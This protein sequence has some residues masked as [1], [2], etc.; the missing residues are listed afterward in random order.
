[1]VNREQLLTE[2]RYEV[3]DSLPKI[4]VGVAIAFLIWLFGVLIFVPLAEALGNPF[5]F[6]LIG[7]SSLI[8]GIILVA[9]ALVIVSIIREVLD[10]TDG[11]A[12]Y[13]A[14]AYATDET[15]DEKVERYRLGFRG[16]AYVLLAVVAY[17][18]F[19]PFIAGIFNVL[20]GIVLIIILI[21]GILVLF[22]VGRIF[23]DEI[24]KKT[25]D[26]TRKVEEERQR[27]REK[28]QQSHGERQDK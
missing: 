16:I 6:G 5:V 1:M 21:W 24:E 3:Y 4:A 25:A 8:S 23:S 14:A 13:A 28:A 18:F 10:A 15:P 19:L 20:A 2:S 7:L 22:R 9:L 26:F 12:G 17:L 27:S 11:L